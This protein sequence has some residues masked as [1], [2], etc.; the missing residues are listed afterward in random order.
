MLESLYNKV[1]VLQPSNFLKERLQHKFFPV[2]IA[3]F[4]KTPILKNICERLLLLTVIFTQENNHMQRCFDL[5]GPKLHKKLTC[6]I[7]VPSPQTTFHRNVIYNFVSIYL[8]RSSRP[9]VFCKKGVLRN[10]AKLTENTCARVSFLIKLQASAK[11]Q[12]LVQVFSENFVKF[13]ITRFF[14][15]LVRWLLLSGSTLY[16]EITCEMLAYV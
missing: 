6:V 16:K 8:G 11:K 2:N 13:Q 1:A 5:P 15:E 3:K 10:I 7:L 12:T 4:L 14:T 9:E